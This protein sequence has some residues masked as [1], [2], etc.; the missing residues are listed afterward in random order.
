VDDLL[1]DLEEAAKKMANHF[2]PDSWEDNDPDHPDG[3]MM[4]KIQ[5]ARMLLDHPVAVYESASR[6]EDPEDDRGSSYAADLVTSGVIDGVRPLKFEALVAYLNDFLDTDPKNKAIV[7]CSFVDVAEHIHRAL[8][9]VVFT[10]SMSAKERDRAVLKFQTDPGTRVFVSTDAG[11]YGLDLPQANLLVNFDLPWQAGLL[12]QRN[13]R[14]RRASS[15]WKHVVVQDFVVE[16]T[17]EERLQDMLRHKIAVSDAFVDGEG[18]LEDGS[19]GSSL[20]S[21]R[22]F[23]EGTSIPLTGSVT[24][25]DELIETFSVSGT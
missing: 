11:G 23:L 16:E 14:I 17:I 24:W 8:P 5:A 18:I 13:A 1:V 7:F 2:L 22:S 21:L 4:A 6:F 3:K 15:E 10:G 12:K 25:K 19:L 9:S 20:D